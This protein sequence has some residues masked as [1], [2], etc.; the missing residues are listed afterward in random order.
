MPK[1]IKNSDPSISLCDIISA[2]LRANH[3]LF[4][5]TIQENSTPQQFY[6]KIDDVTAITI[7]KNNILDFKNKLNELPQESPLKNLSTAFSISLS[8]ITR[9]M[10][11]E[12]NTKYI[13]IYNSFNSEDADR[14]HAVYFVPA[15]ENNIPFNN[16]DTVFAQDCCHCP[17]PR[18][19][20][21]TD[22]LLS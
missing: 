4:F 3:E 11:S 18:I 12:P 10:V 15:D 6:R 1:L 20:N 13:K 5:S 2:P 7:I 22:P 14:R 19:C 8:D 21:T 17:P 16:P 9:M